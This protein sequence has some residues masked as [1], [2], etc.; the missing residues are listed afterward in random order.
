MEK[1]GEM[2]TT[3]TPMKRIIEILSGYKVPVRFTSGIETLIWV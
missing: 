2:A 3:I 1:R